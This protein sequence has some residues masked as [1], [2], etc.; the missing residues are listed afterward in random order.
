MRHPESVVTPFVRNTPFRSISHTSP[1]L[2]K[3]APPPVKKR[4]GCHGDTLT[5]FSHV[6]SDEAVANDVMMTSVDPCSKSAVVSA[7]KAT[8][9]R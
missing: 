9:K 8:C 4:Y 2:V 7:L 6:V 5:D 1:V 3:L